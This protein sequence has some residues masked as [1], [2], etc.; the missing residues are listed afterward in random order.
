MQLHKDSKYKMEIDAGNN[1]YPYSSFLYTKNETLEIHGALVGA[2]GDEKGLDAGKSCDNI[3]I[4]LTWCER[5]PV[6]LDLFLFMPGDDGVTK[7]IQ[8]SAVYWA[9]LT[10]RRSMTYNSSSYS[11]SLDMDDLGTDASTGLVSFSPPQI[12]DN[13]DDVTSFCC[14]CC[15]TRL[16]S[17]FE[18]SSLH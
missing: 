15:R 14:I 9:S 1:Y 7:T 3:V 18:L 5:D 12:I 4:T 11:I 2:I 17:L 10:S 16:E 13:V 6:D 8:D